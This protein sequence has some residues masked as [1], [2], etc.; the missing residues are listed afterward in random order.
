LS[1]IGHDQTS[2]DHR[3]SPVQSTWSNAFN[4]SKGG[5]AVSQ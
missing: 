2:F 4:G 1:V 3:S 5:C